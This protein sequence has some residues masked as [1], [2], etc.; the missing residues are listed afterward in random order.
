[1]KRVAVLTSVFL[2]LLNAQGAKA[3]DAKPGHPQKKT[4]AQSERRAK[5]AIRVTSGAWGSASPAQ[6][7]TLLRAVADEVL[8]HFPGK[9][10][11]AIVVSH[12]HNGPVVLYQK[13]PENEYQVLLSANDER[14]AEYVYEFSHE[15]F[16]ILAGY[17]HHARPNH[18]RH[19]WFE[20]MLAEAVSLH[21]LKRFSLNEIPPPSLQDWSAYVPTLQAFT[22]RALSEP[23]RQLPRNVSFEQW[24]KQ[25]GAALISSP[26]LRKKNEL[27]ANMFLPFLERNPDWLAL[28]YLNVDAPNGEA[29]FY[30][31]LVN[32]YRTTPPSH[33]TF[34][35]DTIQV[36]RL[37]KPADG[38]VG[39][40]PA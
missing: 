38:D 29:S 23:H 25:N 22:H 39:V 36:F 35:V 4:H 11:N 20:E 30:D 28:S 21:T 1:M 27:M 13:G 10:V 19:Q 31:F 17:E 14:W 32:W 6:I 40:A 18:S 24:F 7:E 16:H 9:Q 34:V 5:P 26:Y 8:A 37:K 12:S 15:L 3:V 2:S 33:R